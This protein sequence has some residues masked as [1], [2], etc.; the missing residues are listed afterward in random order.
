MWEVALKCGETLEQVKFWKP[1]LEPWSDYIMVEVK[2]TSMKTSGF[3]FL[4]RRLAALLPVFCIRFTAQTVKWKASLEI[5]KTWI[6]LGKS[7]PNQN[8]AEETM[9]VL[10]HTP[11]E[12]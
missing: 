11:V 5:M 12:L 2:T 7:I 3:S 6:I 8:Q 1:A 9:Y 10:A 4:P